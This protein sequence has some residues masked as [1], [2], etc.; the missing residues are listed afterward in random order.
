MKTGQSVT[1]SKVLA[2]LE[3]EKTLS[4]NSVAIL[5]NQ[6][7]QVSVPTIPPPGSEDP[8][9]AAIVIDNSWSMEPYQD[10]VIQSQRK[11]LDDLR[12]SSLCR[13]KALLVAQYL[14]AEHL[15]Q[16]KEFSV[17]ETG[18]N[19][20]VPK[21]DKQTY[22]FDDYTALYQ[23]VYRVLQDMATYLHF[24]RQE[25]VA[26]QFDLAVFTD[27]EDN[28]SEITAAEVKSVVQD[29]KSKGILRRTIVVGLTGT[30]LSDAKVEAIRDC[31]GFDVAIPIGKSSSEI[32]AAF[33]I[34]SKSIAGSQK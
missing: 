22:T 31:M 23:S 16:L 24:C 15:R 8:V 32:R 28:K 17:L 12:G 29:M 25:F 10:V 21:L 34:V 18:G 13:H 7:R 33:D 14:F 30:D 6:D 4:P 2:E 3:K 5:A 11:L 27:G 20:E 26:S 19:D 1:L 9:Y